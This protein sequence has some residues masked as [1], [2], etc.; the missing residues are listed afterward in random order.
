MN[1]VMSSI[2]I[3]SLKYSFIGFCDL[4]HGNAQTEYNPYEYTRRVCN[5]AQNIEALLK[6]CQDA[7]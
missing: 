7:C 4:K 5:T 2:E 6:V 3:D 1:T